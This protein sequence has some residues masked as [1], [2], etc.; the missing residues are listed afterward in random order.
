MFAL[1]RYPNIEAEWGRKAMTV[2]AVTDYLGVSRKTHYNW[3][4]KGEI[5]SD[6][7]EKLA[8]LFG[9]SID[10]LLELRNR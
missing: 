1:T 10:Y 7:L 5:P 2:S 8:D 6:K 9:T 4:N 3:C